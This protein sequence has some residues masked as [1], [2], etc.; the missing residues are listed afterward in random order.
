MRRV[1]RPAPLYHD[2]FGIFTDRPVAEYRRRTTR[3]L[4]R[5][6]ETRH[7]LW[8]LAVSLAVAAVVLASE[9]AG[10]AVGPSG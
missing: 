10:I 6:D 8:L 1:K 3:R 5:Q 4:R 9:A 7:A 2:G